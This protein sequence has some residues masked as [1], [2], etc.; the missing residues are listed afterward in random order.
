MLIKRRYRKLAK[1][2]KKVNNEHPNGNAALCVNCGKCIERCPQQI[3]I[4]EELEKVDAILGHGKKIS[5]F[6]DL[7]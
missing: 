5:S 7:M 1:S 6:Y 3:N 4:P 2:K